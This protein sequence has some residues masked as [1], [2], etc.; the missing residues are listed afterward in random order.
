LEHLPIWFFFN[1]RKSSNFTTKNGT[2]TNIFKF[3]LDL[4]HLSSEKM[5]VILS[6]FED[7][8]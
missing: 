5:S 4:H 2:I 6:N 8:I 7:F 3:E 1:L